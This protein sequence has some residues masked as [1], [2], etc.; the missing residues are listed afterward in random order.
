M[1]SPR[2]PDPKRDTIA[3]QR[4]LGTAP[5]HAYPLPS[6]EPPPEAQAEAPQVGIPIEVLAQVIGEAEEVLEVM[7]PRIGALVRAL[8]AGEAQP[9]A[10]DT[11]FAG[12]SEGERSFTLRLSLALAESPDAARKARIAQQQFLQAERDLAIAKDAHARFLAADCRAGEVEG[13]SVTKFRGALYPLH[14]L[15]LTFEGHALLQSLFPRPRNQVATRSLE[16]GEGLQDPAAG[17]IAAEGTRA[18]MVERAMR[19]LQ[20]LLE[21]MRSL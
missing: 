8:A 17:A 12:V 19:W 21:D 7:R 4:A 20:D 16:K 2:K 18:S 11:L 10:L 14:N 1:S 6:S 9:S 3:L 5:F 15:A 13:F